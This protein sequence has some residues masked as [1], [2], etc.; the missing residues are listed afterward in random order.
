MSSFD[1]SCEVILKHEGGLVDHPADP[2]GITNFGIS[3]RFMQKTFPLLQKFGVALSFPIPNTPD[4]IRNLSRDQA[5]EIYRTC[6]WDFFRYDKITDQLVATKL[7]DMAVNMGP[8]STTLAATG[9]ANILFQR[10][11]AACGEHVFDS[12]TLVP[13]DYDSANRVDASDLLHAMC[14]QQARF[15]TDLAAAKPNLAVFLPGWLKRSKWPF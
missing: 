1:I 6:W 9:Q 5:R 14:D 12:G 15:Y 10:A 2:G 11:L 3:L 7:F 13:S 8:P 4:M